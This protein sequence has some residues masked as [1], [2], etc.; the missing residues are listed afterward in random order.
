MNLWVVTNILRQSCVIKSDIPI[1]IE[2][3]L[4]FETI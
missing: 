1:F 4:G 3:P 2:Y